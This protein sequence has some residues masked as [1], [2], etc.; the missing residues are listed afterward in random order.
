MTANSAFRSIPVSHLGF[1]CDARKRAVLPA[2]AGS[3][4]VLQDMGVHTKETL[5]EFEDWEAVLERPPESA[6]GAFGD[7][8]V[9]EFSSWTRP[10]LYRLVVPGTALRSPT[11]PIHDGVFSSL[12]R[13]LL[14]YLHDQRCGPFENEWRGPCHMDDAVLSESGEPVDAV[15]GWHDAGDTRQWMAHTLNPILGL[16]ELRHRLGW[17]PERHWAETPWP[18]DLTAEAAWGAAFALKMQDPESGMIWEDVGGGGSARLSA[19]K[20]WYENH[21]GCGGDNS[22]NHFT[23]NVRASGD[24]RRVRQQYNP[25]VQYTIV[26]VL[27]RAALLLEASDPALA[28][29]C[30]KA[31]GRAWSF[32]RSRSRDAFHGWTSVRA[33]RVLAALALEEGGLAE[34]EVAAGVAELLELVDPATRFFFN[35]VGRDQ[36]FRGI[37]HS[38]QP[39]L[40]L[41]G[42]LE[43]HPAHGVAENA[44]DTLEACFR[45]YVEPLR[46]ES[47]FGIVPF[48]L[49]RDPPQTRDRYRPWK[50]GLAYRFFLPDE[51]ETRINHG[52]SGHWTSWAHALAAGGTLLGRSDWHEAALDQI[53]WIVGANPY[54]V[55]MMTGVGFGHPVPHSSFFGA[56]VGGIMVGPRGTLED[57]AFIDVEMRMDWASTEYWNLSLANL[58][59]ALAHLTPTNVPGCPDGLDP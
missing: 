4:F 57:E 48:G 53:Q 10:G 11:F 7:A 43:R 39:L 9:C 25:I 40:A 15:G 55:S 21:A 12:P 42:F 35:D 33:W 30:R 41:I 44:R 19:T 46:A 28:G 51:S 16:F 13:L 23:D 37:L 5:G 49:F 32:V 18:D 34:D 56:H 3:R 36:P 2:G 31:A 14:D 1:L 52:L 50:A 47:P 26:A 27:A 22:E 54:G 20:W 29:R 6:S 58:L 24:E 17:Q 59:Q 8:L 45:H 38:A